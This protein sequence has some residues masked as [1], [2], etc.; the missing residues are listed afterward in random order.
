MY[1]ELRHGRKRRKQESSASDDSGKTGTKNPW[2]TLSQ[3]WG[4][5]DFTEEDF[6]NKPINKEFINKPILKDQGISIKE[7]LGLKQSV[8]E[9]SQH[10]EESEDDSEAESDDEWCKRSKVMRMRMHA[11]DEEAKVQKRRQQIKHQVNNLNY[12]N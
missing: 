9:M 10:S 12:T 11:D 4:V 6:I 1:K 7:R 2:G 8:K 3:T 5:N